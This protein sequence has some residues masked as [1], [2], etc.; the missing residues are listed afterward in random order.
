[1]PSP[2]PNGGPAASLSAVKLMSL[3]ALSTVRARTWPNQPSLQGCRGGAVSVHSHDLVAA[4]SRAKGPAHLCAATRKRQ[5]KSPKGGGIGPR[6]LGRR[7]ESRDEAHLVALWP[8]VTQPKSPA[9]RV[10]PPALLVKKPGKS[11][12]AGDHG[13]ERGRRD[14]DAQ[15]QAS[16]RGSLEARP[17]PRARPL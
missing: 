8:D 6:R 16:T 12:P 14:D 7:C 17:Q 9:R 13:C 11:S 2:L 15:S 4:K 1:M 5:R 10:V 3:T